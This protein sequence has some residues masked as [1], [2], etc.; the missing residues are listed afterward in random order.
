MGIVGIGDGGEEHGHG[1]WG[2][3]PS[4]GGGV[5]ERVGKGARNPAVDAGDL[6]R[7]GRAGT[8]VA[9]EDEGGARG[10]G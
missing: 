1:A 7:D 3:L 2:A 6:V 5:T 4:E 8:H 9:G 10:E